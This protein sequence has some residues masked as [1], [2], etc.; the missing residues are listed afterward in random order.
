MSC[1]R[2]VC[3]C[4]EQDLDD[5]DIDAGEPRAVKRGPR[6]LVLAD[7]LCTWIERLPAIEGKPVARGETR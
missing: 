2:A 3:L 1:W 6:I 7:D 4:F 5:T